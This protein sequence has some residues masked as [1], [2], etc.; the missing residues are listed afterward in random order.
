MITDGPFAETKEQLFGFRIMD[1][2]TKT[3]AADP[4]RNGLLV[5]KINQFGEIYSIFSKSRSR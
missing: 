1:C 4:R 5:N 3:A 2:P